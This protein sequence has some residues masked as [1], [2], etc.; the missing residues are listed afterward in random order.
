MEQSHAHGGREAGDEAMRRA[1]RSAG[2]RVTPTR[3]STLRVMNA[4]G[5]ALDASAILTRVLADSEPSNAAGGAPGHA[6]GEGAIDRVT[7][8][9]TLNSFVEKG[10]AHKVD[11]GDRVFRFSLTDHARCEDHKHDHEHPHLVC[12][13]CGSVRCMTDAQVFIQHKVPALGQ[14][15][16]KSPPP[17]GPATPPTPPTPRVLRQQ[18][19]TVHGKCD[20]CEE[21]EG[22]R[23]GAGRAGPRKR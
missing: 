19:I 13:S 18:D 20:A 10:L 2:L 23:A 4:A 11:P 22:G 6:A 14:R 8:Y 15:A 1:L 21:D 12:D 9:R 16:S 3:L 17:P 7:V 5:E